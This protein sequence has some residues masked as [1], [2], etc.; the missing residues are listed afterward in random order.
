MLDILANLLTK[1]DRTVRILSC[2]ALKKVVCLIPDGIKQSVY[3]SILTH[4]IQLL[5]N[6]DLNLASEALVFLIHLFTTCRHSETNAIP[7]LKDHC[8]LLLVSPMAQNQEQQHIIALLQLLCKNKHVRP[9]ELVKFLM[10]YAANK[11]GF[12]EN[13]A[14]AIGKI[15]L[16]SNS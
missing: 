15:V 8:L 12:Q 9:K 4:S 7:R 11:G 3:H 5:D 16:A 6:K 13:E 1:T 10:N 14:K 2:K